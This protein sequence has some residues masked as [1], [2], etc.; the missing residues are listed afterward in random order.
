[1]GL[2]IAELARRK[3]DSATSPC[4]AVRRINGKKQ[5]MAMIAVALTAAQPGAAYDGSD[6]PPLVCIG[7]ATLNQSNLHH[8]EAI[9][10]SKKLVAAVNRKAYRENSRLVS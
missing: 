8:F 7:N 6:I 9:P 5:P 3:N 10:V 2:G 4:V 1:V